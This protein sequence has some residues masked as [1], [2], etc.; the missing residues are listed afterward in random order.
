MKTGRVA[1][2]LVIV[3]AV[4]V[5]FYLYPRSA[6]VADTEVVSLSSGDIQGTINLE[7]AIASFKGV[8][9]AAAPIGNLRWAPPEPVV[10]WDDIRKANVH[11]PMCVQDVGGEGPF[12]DLMM[13]GVGMPSWKKWIVGFAVPFMGGGDLSEDCLTVAVWAPA[14]SDQST[15]RPLPA[16]VWF[17]G[18]AHKFGSGDAAL[19]DATRLAQ[20]GI[21]VVTVNYRLGVM[22]FMAHPELT[23]GSP[24]RSSGNY[25]TL[26]QIHALKWIR[27]NIHAFGGDPNNVTIFG[28]SAGGHSV[29]Q[30]M[31]SPLSSGLLHRA[32]AQS[33]IGTHQIATLQEGEKAGIRLASTHGITGENQIVA[34]RA[35]PALHVQEM[36]SAQPDLDVL[37]HPVVDGWVLPKSTAAIFADGT[38]APIPLMIGTNADEGTLLAPLIG[39][40]FVNRLPGPK[41]AEEY[42]DLVLDEYPDAGKRLLKLYPADTDDDLYDAVNALFGDD[43]FGMQAWFAANN[44]REAGNPTYLYFLTRTSPSASQSV[45]AYHG[46]DIQFVF[47]SFIPL[48]PKNEFDD[49]LSEQVVS[50]WSNFAKT[51]NPNDKGLPA[52]TGFE[53]L[54]PRELELGER[55]GMRPVERQENYVLLATRIE[56]YLKGLTGAE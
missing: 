42:R 46:A 55:V 48:F 14:K 28:E 11:G 13:D 19:Y 23:S 45:G 15:A 33:G 27:E 49:R 47:G 16:M 3:I 7:T 1:V 18:G 50:Y 54:N 21:I 44:H 56:R 51:G 22:G 26:D 29:G 53:L 37:S 43:F 6:D 36:F 30:V 40:P 32:I 2:Y 52:W 12:L 9:Y 38:Q 25:G 4:A 10:P 34:L 39:S 20:R 24:H 35:L 31:A 41:T 17:H 5:V 8:P